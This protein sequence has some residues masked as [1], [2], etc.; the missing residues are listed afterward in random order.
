MLTACDSAAPAKAEPAKAT[1]AKTE[2]AKAEPAK[3]EPTKSS[4]ITAEPAKLEPTKPDES[5]AAPA[6]GDP[7]VAEPAA[8]EPSKPNDAET[9]ADIAAAV[10][11][12]KTYSDQMCACKDAACAEKITNEM[13]TWGQAM[14]KKYE[15]K[16]EGKPSEAQTKAIEAATT[17]LAECMT[18]LM[19]G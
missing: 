1:P 11:K 9:D 8:A 14:A 12:I 19:A 3:A 5:K 15:G 13:T 4:D 17:R 7:A 2:L 10:I 18:K 16:D 6:A